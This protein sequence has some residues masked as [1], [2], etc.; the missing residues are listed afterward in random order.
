MKRFIVL[1]GLLLAG[2][3]GQVDAGDSRAPAP[4][5]CTLAAL[6]PGDIAAVQPLWVP[7]SLVKSPAYTLGGVIVELQGGDEATLARAQAQAAACASRCGGEGSAV[8]ASVAGQ[9]G[10]LE[11]V[12]RSDD[13][14]T[15]RTMLARAEQ[16][17]HAK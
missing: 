3:A 11:V 7:N 9:D 10:K 5:S 13:P 1:F 16:R 2:C 17:M 14:A 15:A 4:E 8:R 6:Q 12:L